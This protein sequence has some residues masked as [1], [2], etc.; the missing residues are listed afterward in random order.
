MQIKIA[1][2]MLLLTA[3]L[4]SCGKGPASLTGT[5]KVVG[6]DLKPDSLVQPGMIDKESVLKVRFTFKQ[7]STVV[8][9]DGTSASPAGPLRYSIETSGKESTLV[10]KADDQAANP[11]Q[12]SAPPMDQRFRIVQHTSDKLDL[13]QKFEPY[14]FTTHLEAVR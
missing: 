12:P 7:D 13:E 3:V 4:A 2:S 5:W 6:M 1:A 14:T 8:I 10:L 11:G 9:S